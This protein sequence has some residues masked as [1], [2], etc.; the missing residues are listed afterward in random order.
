MANSPRISNIE[1]LITQDGKLVF[2]LSSYVLALAI[3]V[4]GTLLQSSLIGLVI[5]VPYLVING[6]FLGRV[7][8]KNEEIFF[9]LMLGLLSLIVLLGFVSW[10]AVIIYNLS[11]ANVFLV[12]LV[13]S[14][15]CSSLNRKV[16]FSNAH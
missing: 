16:N 4:N 5:S 15:A 10:L 9:R 13:V 1:T 2:T 6:I 7:F 3:Y 8:F 14:T 11:I 12:L